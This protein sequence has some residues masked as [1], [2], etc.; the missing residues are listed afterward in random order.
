MVKSVTTIKY[1]GLLCGTCLALSA[2]HSTLTYAQSYVKSEEK[3]AVQTF[4]FEVLVLRNIQHED[5]PPERYRSKEVLPEDPVEP[6]YAQVKFLK[7]QPPKTLSD[8]IDQML[9]GIKTDIPP[10]YDI[11]GYEIRRYMKSILTPADLNDPILITKKIEDCKKA[12]I[13][14]DYWRKFLNT[15]IIEIQKTIDGGDVT[16][17]ARTSFKY[18]ERI[19]KKFIQ[20]QY[21][22]IDGNLAFL[23]YLQ[24]INGQ[25]QVQY[26]FYDIPDPKKRDKIDQLYNKRQESLREI[27]SYTPFRL[28]IY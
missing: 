4:S 18:H 25:F 19:V 11:Y 12:R 24:S 22:W 3:G 16:D 9:F 15:E 1:L 2:G 8:R 28:M 14:L 6:Q 13:V 23:E 17:S 5:I 26:P 10:E 20:D 27:M 7:A 21:A